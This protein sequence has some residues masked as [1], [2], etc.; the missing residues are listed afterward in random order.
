MLS[1]AVS[2]CFPTSA[3]R[4]VLA[5][6]AL[7]MLA[8]TTAPAA[9]YDSGIVLPRTGD[10]RA[11]REFL[12]NVQQIRLNNCILNFTPY[13]L[14]LV[15]ESQEALAR[16]DFK[17][18]DLYAEY[19]CILSPDIVPVYT[20]RADQLWKENKAH[21]F[22]VARNLSLAII[23]SLSPNNIEDL[24]QVI[25]ENAAALAGSILLSFCCITLLI[26][27]SC[28]PR[29]YHDL[30][31]V[32][33]DAVP[34]F[35]VRIVL[36]MLFAAPL[37][38]RVSLIWLCAWALVLL[39]VYVS[40]PARQVI[41]ALFILFILGIPFLAAIMGFAK[42]M[43]QDTVLN[44]LWKANYGYCDARDTALLENAADLKDLREDI[45]F[46]LGLVYKRNGSFDM[47]RK[48]YDKVLQADPGNYKAAINLG[49]VYFAQNNRDAAIQQ[50]ERATVINSRESAGA[51]FNLSR[52]YQQK[53]MFNESENALNNAKRL[54]LTRVSLYLKGFTVTDNYNRLVI[55]ETIPVFQLWDKGY[56]SFSPVSPLVQ[57]IWRSLAGGV[58]YQNAPFVL[59]AV[60]FFMLYWAGNDRIRIAV[61]CKFCGKPICRR[62]Q[63]TTVSNMICIYCNTLL[64]K[65][66]KLGY[67]VREEKMA[68][69]KHYLNLK[70]MT[71]LVLGY[72]VPGAG[73]FWAGKSVQGSIGI[74]IFFFLIIKTLI[75]LRLEGPW[76]FLFG[77]RVVECSFYAVLLL[78][79]WSGM[80]WYSRKI[81]TGSMEESLILKIIS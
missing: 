12:E 22:A 53:F 63:H 74:L 16:S 70:I 76:D 7:L 60:L 72:A 55:D 47:A 6:L 71:G 27:L 44:L 69:I 20:A 31:H 17:S 14:L 29:L 4:C 67:G 43:S 75:P 51:Y 9:V 79:Y 65:Q 30:R 34:A 61:R 78:A 2:R 57:D 21:W 80:A 59:I 18:A 15:R 68:D 50:Y 42:C 13:S 23:Y 52:V 46:S 58:P 41:T 1:A 48:Y 35:S 10:M 66:S 40:R 8:Y 39:F 73:P 32:L 77:P 64:Q 5:L 33:S 49:N 37:I 56:K 24:S 25:F 36:V 45:F 19:A 38:F 28:L 62:C 11:L 3:V 54:D 81:P 26:I